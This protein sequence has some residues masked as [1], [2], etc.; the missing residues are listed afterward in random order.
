[1]TVIKKKNKAHFQ[2]ENAISFNIIISIGKIYDER[3]KAFF[4]FQ[5]DSSVSNPHYIFIGSNVIQVIEVETHMFVYV[6]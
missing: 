2:L 3:I 6:N 4:T 5:S 1:M